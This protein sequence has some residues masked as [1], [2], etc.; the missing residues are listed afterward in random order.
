MRIG[1]RLFEPHAGLGKP[2]RP[3]HRSKA[4]PNTSGRH[5][6]SRRDESLD[7]T[8]NRPG[9]T[10]TIYQ[11]HR[12]GLAPV[13][14]CALR[15]GRFAPWRHRPQRLRPEYCDGEHQR[16]RHGNEIRS[17]KDEPNAMP[18][19][20]AKGG[21]PT[22]HAKTQRDDQNRYRGLD[23]RPSTVR[24]TARERYENHRQYRQRKDA[25]GDKLRRDSRCPHPEARH[26]HRPGSVGHR[27]GSAGNR[28][29]G[30]DCDRTGRGNRGTRQAK[31]LPRTDEHGDG[32][33]GQ[34]SPGDRLA[35]PAHTVPCVR[36]LRWHVFSSLTN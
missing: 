25:T 3:A 30:R 26:H 10:R 12:F 22:D 21:Q 8:S 13:A 35:D 32:R 11:A 2:D 18:Q 23:H 29:T 20:C 4:N 5:I 28:G 1:A 36:T 19:V 14:H 27:S 17:V 24:H 6:K 9:P 31:Q 33:D 16:G 15:A 34:E 7:A